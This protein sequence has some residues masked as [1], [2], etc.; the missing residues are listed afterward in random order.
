MKAILS[1]ALVLV[2]LWAPSASAADGVLEINQ[3]CVAAGCFA[4]DGAGFPVSITTGGSYRLTSNLSWPGN[5]IQGLNSAISVTGAGMVDLDLGGFTIQGFGSCTGTPVTGCSPSAGNH[6]IQATGTPL[7]IHNGAIR[8]TSGLCLTI[9]NAGPGTV[10]EDLSLS[11][12]NTI[13]L[14]A[15]ALSLSTANEVSAVLRNLR[16]SRSRLVGITLQSPAVVSG[17]TVEGNGTYGMQAVGAYTTVTDSTFSNNFQFGITTAG[18]GF[19]FA[20]GRSSFVS[21][22]EGCGQQVSILG[23]L[24]MGGNV[25][26]GTCQ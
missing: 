24:D 26:E 11:E 5:E 3:D 2:A 15:G 8:G 22:C 17:V 10:I 12:C 19:P 7:H 9:T 16:V 13:G 4:G 20:L 6:G 14:G 1:T 23:L 18:T 25:C 21:N